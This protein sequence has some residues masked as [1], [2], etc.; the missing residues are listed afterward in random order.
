[1]TYGGADLK[2][3]SVLQEHDWKSGYQISK[4]A[5]LW[6]GR[7]YPALNYLERQGIVESKWAEVSYPRPRL[8]RLRV[9]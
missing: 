1:M 8:Y 3:L 5:R 9:N 6:S 4:E 2:I 7:L